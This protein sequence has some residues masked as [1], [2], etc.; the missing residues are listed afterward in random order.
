MLRFNKSLSAVNSEAARLHLKFN[1]PLVGE[2]GGGEGG[3]ETLE[4]LLFWVIELNS[5]GSRSKT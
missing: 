2:G 4:K 5:N 1:L 3:L